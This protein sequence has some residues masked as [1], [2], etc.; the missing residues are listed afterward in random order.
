MT[1]LKYRSYFVFASIQAIIILTYV[2]LL[3]SFSI[4]AK[5]VYP[6]AVVIILITLTELRLDLLAFFVA[7]NEFQ[8]VQ[9]IPLVI[10]SQIF[11][12]DMIWNIQRFPGYFSCLLAQSPSH[13]LTA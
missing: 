12:S 1:H 4:S 6:I 5:Q 11:L 7:N 13:S 8:S 10:L 9:F 3:V 2:F